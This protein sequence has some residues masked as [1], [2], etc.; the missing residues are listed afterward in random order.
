VTDVFSPNRGTGIAAND[1]TTT[2]DLVIDDQTGL[3]TGF[4]GLGGGDVDIT[5]GTGGLTATTPGNELVV[6]TDDTL[7]STSIN[8]FDSL[9]SKHTITVE[10]Y[11]SAIQNRWEWSVA[12]TRGETITVGQQGFVSFNP[13]GSLNT[14]GYAAGADSIVIDPTNGAE[15]M[16]IQID[17]GTPGRWD[18]MTGF[19][20]GIHTAALIGQ[21]GYGMGMLE[22]ISIDQSGNIS[23]MFSNGVSRI[24]AQIILADFNNNGGLMKAGS[25]Y[26]QPSANSGEAVEG[27]AGETISGQITSGALESSA[28][29]IAQEF[30][31]MIT[32]QRGFQANSRI[33]TT[34]D[35]MLEQ[36]VNLKR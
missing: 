34:S 14:F 29:D 6:E 10:F 32:T 21:D 7:H 2:L 25:S 13:D 26:Y 16:R 12:A 23:G 22:K 36:L 5:T 1:V 15:V 28:V 31:S 18:G 24:L 9:G 33:I 11:K 27:V 4:T 3:V 17:A 30:T 20:S 8:V 19:G 35:Q